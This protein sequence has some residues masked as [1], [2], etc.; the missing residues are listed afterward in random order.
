MPTTNPAPLA[1]ASRRV[2]LVD[3]HGAIVEMLKQ[4]VELI[5]GYRVIGHAAEVGAA[6]ELCRREQPDIIV[7]DIMMPP[8]SGLALLGE[9]RGACPLARVLIFSGHLPPA[10][11]QRALSWGVHGL[12]GKM[13]A[14]DEFRHALQAVGSGQVYFSRAA[15]EEIRNL[16]NFKAARVVRLTER[17]RT[18]LREIAN[19]FSSKEI[20]ARLGISIHTVVNHRTRLMKKSGLRGVAQL[21]RYAA[22]IGLVNEVVS[23]TSLGG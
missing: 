18:V 10:A 3:D 12:V 9:L 22:Q 4:V 16:V 1:P 11:I 21:S 2:V 23:A 5:P 19:G 13:A 6:L 7:L 14:L 20:S 15:S 17:E 8:T